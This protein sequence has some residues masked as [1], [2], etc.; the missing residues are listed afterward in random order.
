MALIAASA[1]ADAAPSWRSVGSAATAEPFG[2]QAAAQPD[3]TLQAKWQTLA[4]ESE[5]E[6]EVIALC[7]E[8]RARCTSP[9][10]LRLLDIAEQAQALPGRAR[11]GTIN[12]AINLSIRFSPDVGP[13][14][15][16]DDWSA[17]LATLQR[18]AG[19]CEDYAVAKLTALR[20]AGV[21]ADDL[22]LVIIHDDRRDED[23]AV[24]AARLEGHWLILDNR[25]LVMLEDDALAGIRPIASVDALGIWRRPGDDQ[26]FQLAAN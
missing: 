19:D 23:H 4:R 9:A 20:L 15:P 18:G 1:S 2:M 26:S 25:K 22:R 11:L 8:D 13:S 12:R 7:A 5:A 10:A 3:G 24:A 14:G 21:S 16:S 17:P 6:Q